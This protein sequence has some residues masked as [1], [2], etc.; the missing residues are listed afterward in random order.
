MPNSIV[1]SRGCPHTCDF[2]YKEAFFEGGKGFYTQRVDEALAEI[3]RLPGR[4]LYFLDDHLFGDVRF[5]SAL[6]EGMRGMGRLWQAAGTVQSVLKPGLLEKAVASRAAQPLRRLRD[7]EPAGL[8]AQRKVQNLHRDYGQ[9]VRRLHD[10]G[11]MV[12]GSFVFGMD[13]DD[14]SVFDRTVDWAIGAGHRDRDLPHPHALSRH[15]ALPRAWRRPGA[16][17]IATGTSTTP[18]T[19]SSRRAA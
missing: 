9:A 16:S 17:S 14:A 5:A 8:R 19:S 2:C 3:E 15:R 12:N 18:G 11:V 4:H 13:E 6:F 1:V 10:L 7:A